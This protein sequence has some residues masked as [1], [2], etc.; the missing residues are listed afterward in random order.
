VNAKSFDPRLLYGSPRIDE[1]T[2]WLEADG[3]GG[4]A[5]GTSALL[6][7]RRYHGLLLSATRP[8]SERVLLVNGV[9]VYADTP[10]GAYALSSDRYAPDVTHPDGSARVRTFTT[11]RWPS[12]TFDLGPTSIAFELLVVH[13]MPATILRWRKTGD[14]PISLRVR[15]LLSCRDL[16]ALAHANDS[17]RFASERTGDRIVWRPYE[18]APGIVCAQNGAFTH[19]PEWYRN[20]LYTEER[21]RGLDH[22]ED[23]ASP[24]EL[25]FSLEE[26]ASIVFACETEETQAAL[27]GG[28]GAFVA[29]AIERERSRRAAFPTRLHRAADAYVV[30]RGR[31]RT[32]IAGYPWFGDWGR[33]TFLALRG[34]CL[35]TDRLELARDI[36][37]EWS[38]AVSDGMLPNRFPDR[39]DRPEYNSV[40]ASLAYVLAVG[41][42]LARTTPSADDVRRLEAAVRAILDGYRRGTRHG[43]RADDDGLLRAGEPGVQLTWMDAK[44][45]DWVVTPRIGKPVEVQALW[46][47]ALDVGSRF[48]RAL[49]PLADRAEQ[50][51]RSRFWS[52]E[53]GYL[54]DVADADHR[55]GAI[56]ASFRPNQIFAAGG[57]PRMLVPIEIARR[58]VD[59]VEARL[60]T[61]L[62][63]RT[64]AP[65]EDGYAPR[66]EGGV[67]ER[68]G[69]YHQGTVWP[70]LIGPFTDAWI[71]THGDDAEARRLARERFVDPLLDHLDRAGVDHVS[72]IAD[73]ERPHRPRGC[74]FQA[75]SVSELLR[76]VVELS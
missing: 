4:F 29:E 33:D 18:D 55:S 25:R 47:N 13:G 56:D 53:R 16:H 22:L 21:A 15:P 60:W 20:F 8:P 41:E 2:E 40:D 35:A 34:L 12:W 43:I 38:G 37:L 7:T 65:G 10:R 44:V 74:P 62:G 6:R 73:A 11:E 23:L 31:G 19:A 67:R 17:F 66:Y 71:R 54:C 27:E 68:D 63:L 75:W 1:A 39:G 14:E 76:L 26:P 51:F 50:S 46:V 42:Y 64:L 58:V 48:D 59:A 3:L 30:V 69:A 32:V 9:I 45:G 57:L 61:P 24:G 28:V 52:E 70:W 36:L 49:G 5:S 72:E